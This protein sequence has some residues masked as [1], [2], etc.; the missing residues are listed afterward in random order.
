VGGG[1][2]CKKSSALTAG[3]AGSAP[4]LR[5]YYKYIDRQE[6]DR[7]YQSKLASEYEHAQQQQHSDGM[8]ASRRSQ[9]PELGHL[10]RQKSRLTSNAGSQA[11]ADMSERERE[12]ERERA[13]LAC[14]LA[15]THTLTP[16]HHRASV[17]VR[18]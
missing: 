17:C 11:A 16:S 13:L 14:L 8:A 1:R 10:G 15:R 3:G 2:G 18:V 5:Y 12:R 4:T 7:E 6:T 9:S